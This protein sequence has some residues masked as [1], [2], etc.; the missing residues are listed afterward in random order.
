MLFCTTR[1]GAQGFD[2]EY[3]ARL[4]FE[5]PRLYLGASAG[6]E[7]GRHTGELNYIERQFVC[8]RYPSGEGVGYRLGIHG[9]WWWKADICYTATVGY[10]LISAEFS[11]KAEPITLANKKILQTE[12]FLSTSLQCLSVEAAAKWRMGDSH[13]WL[14]GGAET[15]IVA[16]LVSNQGERVLTPDDYEFSTTPPSREKILS[17]QD[18]FDV[19]SLTISPIIGVGYD[20][21]MGK[22]VYLSPQLRIGFPLLNQSSLADWRIWTLGVQCNLVFGL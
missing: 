5:I 9:E 18:V 11:Q 6:I 3:S 20:A 2:W 1:S 15:R 21:D 17:D 22:G 13:L 12:Y 10:H 4:P 19:R 16:G 8:T 7:Y 14:S